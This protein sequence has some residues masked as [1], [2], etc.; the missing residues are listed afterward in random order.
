MKRNIIKKIFL[1]ML[2]CALLVGC[3]NS[4]S[5]TTKNEKETKETVNINYAGS[6]SNSVLCVMKHEKLMEKYLPEETTVNWTGSAA[7][8][9]IRDGI[10]SGSIDIGAYAMP[11]YIMGT[12]NDLPLTMISALGNTP[13]KLYSN[14]DTI[15]NISDF[16]STD[17][18][19]VVGLGSTLQIAML[20]EIKEEG[21]DGSTFDNVWTVMSHADGLAALSG[22]NDIQGLL[23]TFPTTLKADATETIHEVYDLSDIALDYGIGTVNV[24]TNELYENHPEIIEAFLSAQEDAI[25]MYKDDPETFAQILADDWEIDVQIVLDTLEVM[26]PEMEIVGYNKQTDLLYELGLLEKEAVPFEELGN[27]EKLLELSGK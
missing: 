18:I 26:P 21:L 1:C 4:T 9:E 24:C 27:Y 8:S 25:Q 23:L 19:S 2:V 6:F 7:A 10:I 13:I 20:A 22:G 17:K 11:T 5:S 14:S 3:G 12:L 16:I 15:N